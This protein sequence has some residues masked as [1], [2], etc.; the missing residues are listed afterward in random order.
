MTEIYG[1]VIRNPVGRILTFIRI[2]AAGIQNNEEPDRSEDKRLTDLLLN[3]T[4][5]N[6]L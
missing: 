6:T 5:R 1:A 4:S 3:G 2:N